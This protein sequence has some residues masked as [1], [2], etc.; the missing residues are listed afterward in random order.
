MSKV[1]L[2]NPGPAGKANYGLT[3]PHSLGYLASY[4]EQHDVEVRIVDQLAGDGVLHRLK[5]L[6]W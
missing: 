3:E 2:V 5:S 4:L 1:A 6:R